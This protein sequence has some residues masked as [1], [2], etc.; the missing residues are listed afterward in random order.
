M[1]QPKKQLCEKGKDPAEC[2]PEQIQEC[3]GE[4]SVHEC[5]T[6]DCEQPANPGDC[7]EEQVRKCHG[8][9][10]QHPCAQA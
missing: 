7:S 8:S 1:C 9:V 4:V 5:E 10:A 3:H 2:G 6:T